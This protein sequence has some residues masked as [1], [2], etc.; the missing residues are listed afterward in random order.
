MEIQEFLARLNASGSELRYRLP[1]EAEW[2]YACRAGTTTPFSTGANLT[3]EQANYNGSFPY[4]DFPAGAY[5][6]HPTAA[7]TF[8]LNPWGLADMHGNVWEWTSD[9]YGPYT[10]GSVVDPQGAPSGEKRVIRGGSWYFDANSARCALALQP[11]AAGSRIQSWF[12]GSG[13][14]TGAMNAY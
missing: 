9:W 13:R 14:S 6:E 2:E 11:L 4:A 8:P 1:T 7:G 3:T 12:S 5:R 10:A